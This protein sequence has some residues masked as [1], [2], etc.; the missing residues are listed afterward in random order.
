M[1]EKQYRILIVED[2][3]VNIE[4]LRELL[5]QD[6]DLL[7]AERGSEAIRRMVKSINEMLNIQM[8]QSSSFNLNMAKFDLHARITALLPDWEVLAGKKKIEIRLCLVDNLPSAIGDT[9]KFKDVMEN[10]I[11][12]AVKF[13]HPNTI[14]EVCAKKIAGGFVE[15]RVKDRG[16]GITEE[17][18]KRVFSK[19]QKLSARPTAG[20]TSTGLGLSIVKRLVELMGGEVGVR[21]KGRN[22]GSEFWFT[23]KS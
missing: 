11:E 9:E 15:I 14:V 7:I 6:Y 10:L 1:N 4:V 12:N 22:K 21:S 13:S 8:I 18:K 20:E 5:E 3:P 19:F 16:L 2:D 23:L 17:D